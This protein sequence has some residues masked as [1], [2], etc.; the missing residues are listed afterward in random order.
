[1]F[2][3]FYTPWKDWS[4]FSWFVGV[5]IAAVVYVLISSRDFRQPEL[6]P[7]EQEAQA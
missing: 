5:I 1:L 4:A 3:A 7:L 6:A 2:V